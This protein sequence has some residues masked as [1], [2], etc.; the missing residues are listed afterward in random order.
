MALIVMVSASGSPG[1]T[2]TA[3]G[4][5]W[6]W[7]RPVMLVEADPTGGSA[8][9]AGPLRGQWTPRDGLIDLA[10]AAQGGTVTERLATVAQQIPGTKIHL[11][12]GVRSHVQSRALRALWQPLAAA[13]KGLDGHGQDVIVD[14]GRLGLE[15]SPTPLMKAADL[16]LLVVRT[17]L[18]SLSAARSWAETLRQDLESAGAASSLGLLLVG[19]GD[20]YSAREVSKVLGMPVLA[21]VAWDPQAV[22]VFSRGA[23]P[24]KRFRS[25]RLMRS[26]QATEAAIN[27]WVAA[28]RADLE[29]TRSGV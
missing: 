5:A 21:S 22:Q 6:S 12:S 11:L 8:V 29:E 15:G 14:A 3:T 17:D 18:V 2:S 25:G 1:V 16:T 13:L 24:R 26:L 20:P 19:E 27:S 7:Q 10:V 28:A 4:L 23:T 9:L